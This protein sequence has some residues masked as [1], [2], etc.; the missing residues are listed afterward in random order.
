MAL[1]RV[2]SPYKQVFFYIMSKGMTGAEYFEASNSLFHVIRFYMV[3]AVNLVSQNA[4]LNY[5]GPERA[6]A[7][8]W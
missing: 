8:V 5:S 4:D 3:D 7:N 6:V 1:N 2:T